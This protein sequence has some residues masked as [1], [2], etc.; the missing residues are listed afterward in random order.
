MNEQIFLAINGLAN[1]SHFLDSLGIFFAEYFLYIFAL[2]IVILWFAKPWR[3]YAYQALASAIISRLI[4]VEIIK[5]FANHPRPYEIVS[6]IKQLLVDTE[7]GNSFPSG[8]TVIFFS[9]AFAFYGTKLFWPFV[10][11]A[12]LGSISRVFVGVHFPADVAASVIIAALTVWL[13]RMLFRKYSAD[14]KNN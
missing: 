1:K 7:T 9:F 4:I 8:H 2:I 13:V 6:G 12:A 3:I 5:R 10:F 14:L 11:L